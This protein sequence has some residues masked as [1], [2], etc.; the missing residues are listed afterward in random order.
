MIDPDKVAPPGAQLL[1]REWLGFDDVE[2]TL[3]VRYRGQPAFANR[4]GTIAGGF[5]AAMLD[6]AAG[7]CG[8]ADIP[9]DQ[10][11]VTRN[12]EVRFLAPAHVGPLTATARV[13][14]RTEREVVVEARLADGQGTVVANAKAQLSVLR[15]RSFILDEHFIAD[16]GAAPTPLPDPQP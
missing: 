10:T 2:K 5:L 9:K 8:M 3:S 16:V 4:H 12:L 15:K 13:L 7:L 14:S 1:G 11:V 6:S